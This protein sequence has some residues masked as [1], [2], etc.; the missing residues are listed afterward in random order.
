MSTPINSGVD[1]TLAVAAS[2]GQAGANGGQYVLHLCS[3]N[4]TDLA[5]IQVGIS[6]S[7]GSFVAAT[8]LE[9]AFL[10]PALQSRTY[11]PISLNAL[12][13]VV[14]ESDI[15]DINAVLMGVDK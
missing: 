15:D 10:L 6:S 3:R 9:E 14:V 12:E 11:G 1:L 2:A 5:T 8:K 13:H 7:S 4:A